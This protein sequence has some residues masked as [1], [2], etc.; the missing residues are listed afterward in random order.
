MGVSADDRK[1]LGSLLLD[2]GGKGDIE[3]VRSLLRCSADVNAKDC[4]NETPLWKASCNGH[5]Q[6]VKALL[7]S[8]ASIN[9]QSRNCCRTPIVIAVDRGR[10]D[11]VKLL[12]GRG[13]ELPAGDVLSRKLR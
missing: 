5:A 12:R 11:C 6:V 4:F 10:S 9:Y 13:A 8:D 2:S 1:A 7:D 3:Q